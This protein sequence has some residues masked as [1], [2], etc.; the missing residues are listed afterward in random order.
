MYN[1]KDERIPAMNKVGGGGG[2][3]SFMEKV[4]ARAALNNYLN[5]NWPT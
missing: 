4:V 1:V 5:P 3:D 2:G